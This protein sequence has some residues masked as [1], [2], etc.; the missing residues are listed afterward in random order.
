MMQ[1][2]SRCTAHRR[3]SGF[4][5]VEVLLVLAIMALFATLFIPGVNSIL[6]EIDARVPEQIVRHTIWRAHGAPLRAS[7]TVI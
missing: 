1:S 3:L 6:R 5:L 7:R 4:T 2:R